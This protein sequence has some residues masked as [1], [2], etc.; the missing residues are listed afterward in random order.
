MMLRPSGTMSHHFVL[1]VLIAFG[2][3]YRYDGKF[4]TIRKV[5]QDWVLCWFA[6]QFAVGFGLFKLLFPYQFRTVPSTHSLGGLTLPAS[7]SG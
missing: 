4:P 2:W 1:C 5:G 7:L 6:A 3:F